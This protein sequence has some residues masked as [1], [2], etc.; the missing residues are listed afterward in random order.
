M[1]LAEADEEKIRS[2]L[3]NILNGNPDTEGMKTMPTYYLSGEGDEQVPV[4]FATLE[5]WTKRTQTN[6]ILGM[7][8][9]E[10]KKVGTTHDDPV[11]PPVVL[12]NTFSVTGRW[13]N[14]INNG[15][16]DE[17]SSGIFTAIGNFTGYLYNIDAFKIVDNVAGVVWNAYRN[18]SSAD[19]RDGLVEG[20]L[21]YKTYKTTIGIIDQPLTR[22]DITKNAALFAQPYDEQNRKYTY[23]FLGWSKTPQDWSMYNTDTVTAEMLKGKYLT[24]AD[25]GIDER[26]NYL[27]DNNKQIVERG[28]VQ[29]FA[30]YSRALRT[31]RITFNYYNE[32]SNY[33]TLYYE[34]V[35][36]G[37]TFNIEHLHRITLRD[38]E[39]DRHSGG[40]RYIFKE[41]P[42]TESF[43]VTGDRV[44]DAVYD[45]YPD[46][47]R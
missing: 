2:W 12:Y 36:Y 24:D 26:G 37:K 28:S 3:L 11:V 30:I 23:T 43:V 16:R 14:Y 7:S 18:N 46:F 22:V 25:W 40:L 13:Y 27:P 38:G 34:D 32:N 10:F 4:D 31:Y 21:T 1:P 35:E 29:Y 39:I 19:Y 41:W 17:V 9:Y 33:T 15:Q 44:F 6:V 45:I 5:W 8:V 42:I 20:D 47:H